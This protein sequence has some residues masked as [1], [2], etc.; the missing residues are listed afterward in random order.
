M[1]EATWQH[2]L[3]IQ[4]RCHRQHLVILNQ[5]LKVVSQ[6]YLKQTWTI[7]YLYTTSVPR[8]SW[9]RFS[10]QMAV[11]QEFYLSRLANIHP[12]YLNLIAFQW[13]CDLKTFIS[14]GATEYRQC[15]GLTRSFLIKR[16]LLCPCKGEGSQ[17]TC[18]HWLIEK[19]WCTI[20]VI[21]PN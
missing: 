6:R 12:I 4:Q 1:P 20:M 5:L 19:L 7:Q 3:W 9:L 21:E 16:A 10:P 17:Y 15:V 2:Q 18:S 13:F 8:S 14:V 11:L